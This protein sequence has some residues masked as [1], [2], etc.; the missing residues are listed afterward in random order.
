MLTRRSWLRRL[1]VQITVDLPQTST[2]KRLR[3]KRPHHST[4]E[5]LELRTLLTA[6]TVT[7]IELIGSELTTSSTLRWDVTFDQSVE[8][9]DATDF[10]ADTVGPLSFSEISATGSGSAYQVVISGVSGNGTIG[11]NLFDDDSIVN[12]LNEP[13]EGNGTPVGDFWGQVATVD[14]TSP[15]L[16]SILRETP[17]TASTNLSSVTFI[18]EFSEPVTGVDAT[19]FLRS[20]TGTVAAT[21]TTVTAVSP[22]QY[23]VTVSGITGIGSIGLELNYNGSV[24]DT[25]G[26]IL[27]SQNVAASF[28][29]EIAIGTGALPTSVLTADINGDGKADVVSVNVETDSVSIL[30]GNGNGTFQVARTFATGGGPWSVATGDLN[31]DGKLD[32][33]TANFY[34]DTVSVLLGLGNGSFQAQQTFSTELSPYAVTIG[35]LNGDQ[36]LDLVVANSTFGGTVSVLLGI[37]DGSFSGQIPYAVGSLPESVALGDVNGDQIPDIVVAN[38]FDNTVS[39][40][41]GIGDGTFQEQ[42]VIEAGSAPHSIVLA[43]LNDDGNLDIIVANSY[44]FSVGIHYGNGDGSFQFRELLATEV[45]PFAL[46]LG[47]LNRDGRLDIATA[48]FDNDSVSILLA[49][50]SGTFDEPRTFVAASGPRSITAADIDGDGNPDLIVAA[51][52]DNTIGVLKGNDSIFK[53]AYTITSTA[54]LNDP[55]VLSTASSLNYTENQPAV[56]INP[57]VN[58]FDADDHFLSSATVRISANYTPGQDI[59]AFKGDALTTGGI[60]GSFD[61]ITGTLTLTSIDLEESPDQFQAALRLVTYQNTSNN[62][63]TQPRQIQFQVDDGELLSNVLTNQITIAATNG[64]PVLAAP[65]VLTYREGQAATIINSVISVSDSDSSTFAFA[66]VRISGNYSRFQDGLAFQGNGA[67]GDITGDFNSTTGTLVLTSPSGTATAAQFQAA[68]RLVTYFNSSSTPSTLARTVL[69]QISD[70]RSLSNSLT[71]TIKVT[72]VNSPTVLTGV[73]SVAA[74]EKQSV[75]IN[76][77]ISISDVDTTALTSAT[78]RITSKYVIGQDV[79]EFVGR[80]TTGS[81]VGSF[82]SATG[83]LTLSSPSATIAQFEAALR[84]VT[85]R[86]TSSTP[87]L[88]PRSVTYQ[89][90]DGSVLSNSIVSQVTV[91]S[92]NDPPVIAGSRNLT[93]TEGEPWKVISPAFV[94]SDADSTA[95]LSVSVRISS[96]Y[97]ADQDELSFVGNSTTGNITGSYNS[98]TGTLTLISPGASATLA[99]FQAALRLVSYRNISTSPSLSPRTVT[100][101]VSDRAVQSTPVVSTISIIPLNDAPTLQ[102]GNAVVHRVGLTSSTINP[103]ILVGDVDDST[104]GSATVRITQNYVFGQDEL[105]FVPNPLTM[106]N[107]TGVFNAATGTLTLTSLNSTATLS[108]FQAA[109]RDVSY[110]NSN[111]STPAASRT[112]EFQISD[113]SASS[114][115]VSSL[116]TIRSSGATPSI[117]GFK[118][119]SYRERQAPIVVNSMVTLSDVDSPRLASATVRISANASTK[120]DVLEFT[121]TSATGNIYGQ[122][123]SAT[124]VLTLIS[125]GATATVA[126]FQAA[127]RLVKYSNTSSNPS[128]LP[129]S[130][131]YQVSDGTSSSNTVTSIVNIIAL[132]EA[133]VLAG[134]NSLVV[135]TGQTA[136]A[137]SPALTVTDIDSSTMSTATVRISANY[138]P[139]QDVLGFVSNPATTGNIVGSFNATTAT[140]TLTSANSSA[141]V[142]Q[143]QAALRLVTY[144]NQ[145]SSPS[146]LVRSVTYQIKDGALNSNSLVSVVS[147]VTASSAPSLNGSSTVKYTEK[148][149]PKVVNPTIQVTDSSSAS[150]ASATVRISANYSRS[151]DVLNF[152]GNAATGNISGSFDPQSGSLTLISVNATATVAQFQAALR[153][154]TYSNSSPTPS[155][156]PRTISFQVSN[157]S[158]SSNS[159]DSILTITA[160]Q[161]AP[162]ISGSS[163]IV[164]QERVA[165]AINPTIAL[166]GIDQTKLSSA[167]ISLSNGYSADQDVLNFVRNSSTGN[168][169]GSFDSKTGVM[170]LTSANSSATIA[171]F[172]A[173]LRLVTYQNT[174]SSPTVGVRSVDFQVF[175]GSLGSNLLTSVISVTSVNDGPTVTGVKNL[176]YTE[177]QSATILNNS[178]IVSDLD[179]STLAWASVTISA[180]YS[181]GQDLLGFVGNSSTGNIFGSFNPV[182]GTLLLISPGASATI[183]Q[184][185]A[186]LRLVT[187]RNTSSAPSILTRSIAMRVSDGVAVSSPLTSTVTVTAVNTAPV[188]T[189]TSAVIVASTGLAVPINTTIVVSDADNAK[190]SSATVRISANY[191]AGQDILEFVGSSRRTGNIVGSFNSVTGTLTLT[192]AGARATVAEF[193]AALRL[194]SYRNTSSNPSKSARSIEFVASDGNSS[195]N[196]A[197]SLVTIKVAGEAPVITNANTVAYS[198]NQPPVQVNPGIILSDDDSVRLASATVTISHHFLIEEDVLEF[199]GNSTTGNIVGSYNNTTGVL[200]LIS[201]GASA[202]LAQF[203]NALRLVTYSNISD[204][205][206]PVSRSITFQVSD[207]SNLSAISTSTVIVQ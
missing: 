123:H 198:E 2:C 35:D 186:A 155:L 122:Y 59:L 12:S 174:S 163:G 158:L 165:A 31:G 27:T 94:L 114:N 88:S 183:A 184:F 130:I 95:L 76:T 189:G 133:P 51:F 79:L 96:N 142:A 166:S 157:S 103:T 120:Q 89:V 18:A 77:R 85:Y 121:P 82:D 22:T 78:V 136:T 187:Y 193:Q 128:T 33:V 4:A 86:N 129:R 105:V 8:G 115:V 201:A 11:L 132:N 75:P 91:V 124:G 73:T 93:Y 127:L 36:K 7:S 195:S 61:P 173:A 37:G 21:R 152:V 111:P 144:S 135:E 203:Q 146:I 137:I 1:W 175:D 32:L 194:V 148:E 117:L 74:G 16:V 5:V 67:T 206:T 34:D 149:A 109:L 108:Q 151:Q 92:V 112:V 188:L 154:V 138:A 25:V 125:P 192:S 126:Q 143:F 64:A 42:L 84:L 24:R 10:F 30:L 58:L 47:D 110:L 131:T 60:V 147:V 134:A 101:Q 70:G 161:D 141:T 200:T 65:K 170:T 38:E 72:A 29:D 49:N 118:T 41:L 185:Q 177:N 14:R 168:I 98:A 13:L 26:N 202:T 45:N 54:T 172:Q 179:D 55:P 181:A 167:K 169:L 15:W 139:G 99:Q 160:V 182:S 178:L 113:G 3:A 19:D 164:V 71:N 119:V 9:V 28:S 69:Y 196:I 57:S 23:Q 162:V 190:L 66:T 40:L 140:L 153:L 159:V 62:P 106:G 180:N 56:V 80:S 6:P 102:G 39:V 204:D 68:L 44:D 207:G 63:N 20:T 52:Y 191:A 50:S 116:I 90:S 199:I 97:A 145:S 53:E 171:Q 156:L 87:L 176:T 107:I 205:A 48:N 43:D 150:L 81:I 100:F 197:R 83:T 46:A 104:L 17:A